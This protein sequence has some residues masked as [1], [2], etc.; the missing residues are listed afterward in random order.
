MLFS[1]YDFFLI[2]I[3]FCWLFLLVKFALRS[4]PI[5]P[6]NRWAEG[7]PILDFEVLVAGHSQKSDRLSSISQSRTFSDRR[8][9]ESQSVS[10][11]LTS[12]LRGDAL[13]T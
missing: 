1:S 5:S 8:P 11:P 10:R 6:I 13:T 4:P 7:L 12:V 3:C 9:G 2:F